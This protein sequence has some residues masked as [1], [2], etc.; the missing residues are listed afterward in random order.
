MKRFKS[1]MAEEQKLLSVFYDKEFKVKKA[2]EL[3]DW[4]VLE[5]LISD[6]QALAREI[7]KTEEERHRTFSELKR[8]SGEPEDAGFYKVAV[9]FSEQDRNE[10]AGL[11]RNLKLTVVRLQALTFGIDSYVRAVSSTMQTVLNQLFPFRKGKFYSEPEVKGNE[12][13]A[14][15]LNTEL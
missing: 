10:C 1:L 15:V 12:S 3:S 13:L 7:E 5:P 4:K 14:S 2:I 9:N 8:L 6:G 11:Y